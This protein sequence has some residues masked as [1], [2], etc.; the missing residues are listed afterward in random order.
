MAEA[1]ESWETPAAEAPVAEDAAPA[2]VEAPAPVEDSGSSS[3]SSSA[4]TPKVPTESTISLDDDDFDGEDEVGEGEGEGAPSGEKAVIPEDNRE[5][6][7]VIFIGHVDAGKSTISGNVLYL[8]GMVD[9]RTI[10]KYQRE[11]KEKNR[12]TWFLAFIMDTN[13]EERAKGKTVEVGRAHFESAVKRFTILDAPGHKNYVPNMI[14]GAAQADVGILVISAR[15]GEFETGFEGGGQTREHA[16]LCKTLGVRKLIVA[17]NKMDEPTVNWDQERFNTIEE[18]LKPF[19]KSIGYGPKDIQFLPVS[20]Y[21][22]ANIKEKLSSEA[23]PW[24]NGPTLL[25]ALDNLEPFGRNPEGPLRIPLLDKYRDK[26]CT[27]ALGKIE[28]GTIKVGD[29]VTVMPN[30]QQVEVAFIELE[31]GEVARAKPGENANIGLKDISISDVQQGFVICGPLNTELIPC[32]SRFEA[33]LVILDL[34][35]TKAIVSAGYSAVVHIH[36]CVEEA[37]I[38]KILSVLDKKT[39][40]KSKRPPPFA[41]KGDVIDVIIE[42]QR[43]ICIETFDNLQQLGRFTLRDEGKTIAIGKITKVLP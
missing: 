14:G 19:L 33:Q 23:C 2:V 3:S 22:G 41:K 38:E 10:E 9:S 36:T 15:K 37:T 6:L 34:L 4:P 13:E 25:E 29:L 28:S 21:T 42:T 39:K 30:K 32:V 27:I 35:P 5:H 16:T 11:A 43:T 1:S 31:T 26:G 18:K 40:K 24:Y 7:N 12:G 17:I 20:G 8:T